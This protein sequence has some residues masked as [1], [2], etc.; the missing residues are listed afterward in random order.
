AGPGGPGVR[1]GA[2]PD[3]LG[4]EGGIVHPT[5]GGLVDLVLHLLDLDG[6]LVLARAQVRV[7]AVLP[8]AHR[9]VRR[10]RR[11]PHRLSSLRPRHPC[12]T[13]RAPLESL[14]WLDCS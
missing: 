2:V 5:C 10:R 3:L 12:N 11:L 4:V 14:L 8:A 7:R 9:L 13:A 6:A 1:G